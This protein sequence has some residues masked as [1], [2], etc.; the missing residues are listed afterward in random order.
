MSAVALK[1]WPANWPSS[2]LRQSGFTTDSGGHVE[3]LLLDANKRLAESASDWRSLAHAGI[4]Q[5]A[6]DAS[7]D[8]GDGGSAR[9]VDAT[10]KAYA[11][12]LV[13]MLPAYLPAPEPVAELD[14][15]LALVWDLG[16]NAVFS[17][18]VSSGGVLHY[19][20]VIGDGE[21]KRRHG[22]AQLRGELPVEISRALQN[23]ALSRVA[24]R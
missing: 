5:V 8:D 20:G 10:A 2:P 12:A 19:A 3:K 6:L 18:S 4:E 7:A 17:V 23:L 11:H 1:Y 13:D 21:E 9:A 14:G 24:N 16:R 22:R 15:D